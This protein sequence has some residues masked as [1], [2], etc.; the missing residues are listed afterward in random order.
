[1]ETTVFVQRDFTQMM[2]VAARLVDLKDMTI[3]PIRKPSLKLQ[4]TS[5]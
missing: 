3:E 1:M 4:E 5:A 2:E